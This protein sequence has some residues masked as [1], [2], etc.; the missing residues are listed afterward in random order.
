[1]PNTSQNR[2]GSMNPDRRCAVALSGRNALRRALV[3][4]C[5]LLLGLLLALLSLPAPAAPQ[6]EETACNSTQSMVQAAAGRR[7]MANRQYEVAVN[8]FRSALEA[9]PQEL[10]HHLSLAAALT[11]LGNLD[12]AI[13]EA[14][15]YLRFRPDSVD[16]RLLLANACFR[17]Q[18]FDECRQA[19]EQV[20]ASDSRNLPALQL[21]ANADY[22][23]GNDEAAIQ[24]LIRA[25]ALHPN[26]S[27][28]AYMLGRIYFQQN[29]V[30][31]ALGQFQRVLKLDP[32]SYKAYDNLG[33]CYEA[34]NQA[35][36]AIQHYMAAIKLVYEDHPEYEWPYANLAELL[37]KRDEPKKAFSLAAEAAK[38]NP[39]SARN[40][41]LAGKALWKLEET[42]LALKWLDQSSRLDANYA[43]PH[44]LLGQ[45]YQRLGRSEDAKRELREF[46]RIS[47]DAP[48]SRR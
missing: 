46:Q 34:L 30:E 22:L 20:L 29:R 3:P 16:A 7:A 28:T 45:I 23:L 24:T 48:R 33:L 13:R 12:D 19:A 10:A 31:L 8:S 39:A 37:L 42:D 35:E 40:F 27:E 1:M 47:K 36:V 9:C 21:R 44:Y 43:E 2:E 4:L 38:R 6:L 5:G 26:D 41:Y 14:R 18:R 11:S 32:G 15:E 17:A 25:L